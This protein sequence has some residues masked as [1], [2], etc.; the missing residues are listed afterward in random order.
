MVFMVKI[1]LVYKKEATVMR[2]WFVSTFGI[3]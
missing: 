1:T 3:A 2:Q